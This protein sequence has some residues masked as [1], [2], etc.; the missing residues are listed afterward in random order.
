MKQ[1]V[2]FPAAASVAALVL[3]VL[4]AGCEPETIGGPCPYA[5]YPGTATIRS[6]VPDTLTDRKCENAVFI[7]FDF[8]PDDSTA[9]DRYR[10]PAWPDTGRTFDIFGMK[11]IPAGWADKEGLTVGSEHRSTRKEIR[12]GPCTPLIF[13]F[14]EIDYSDWIDYCD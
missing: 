13:D 5:D 4:L 1:I 11:S 2:Y 14:P 3:S 6:V 9:V 8:S 7:T 12:T 10:F